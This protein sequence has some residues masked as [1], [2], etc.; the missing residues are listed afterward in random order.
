MAPRTE[1]VVLRLGAVCW[2]TAPGIDVGMATSIPPHNL[3]EVCH[4]L[5]NDAGD[6]RPE[7]AQCAV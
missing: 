6:P 2:S 7:Y 3:G 4:A 1:P 5:L